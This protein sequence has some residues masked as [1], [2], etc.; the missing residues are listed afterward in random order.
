M[1]RS[2]ADLGYVEEMSQRQEVGFLTAMLAAEVGL[3]A[4]MFLE[5]D[6]FIGW[7]NVAFMLMGAVVMQTFA[8]IDSKLDHR[9]R[10]FAW[11]ALWLA[12]SLGCASFMFYLFVLQQILVGLACLGLACWGF[13][14]VDHYLQQARK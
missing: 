2:S 5:K 4:W 9:P 6:L 10:S 12:F 1:R 11:A 8:M 3:A 13:F 7:Q 14:M